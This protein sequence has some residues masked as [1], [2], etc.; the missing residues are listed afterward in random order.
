[1]GFVFVVNAD[2]KADGNQVAGVALLRAFNFIGEDSELSHAFSSIVAVSM[3][4][5]NMNKS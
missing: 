4:R 2:E 5:I 1:I 3:E